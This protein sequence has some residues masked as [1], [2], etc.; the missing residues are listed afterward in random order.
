MKEFFRKVLDEVIMWA[1]LKKL[2]RFECHTANNRNEDL[3]K[4][5]LKIKMLRI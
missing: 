3:I 5:I 2:Q 1:S 4:S